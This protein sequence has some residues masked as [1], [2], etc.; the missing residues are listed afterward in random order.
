MAMPESANTRTVMVIGESN[1]GKT[2]YGAQL[3]QRLN[4]Q[5]SVLQM[6]AMP[7]NM[8][9][10]E[11]AMRRIHDGL[12]AEH[13]S[14]TVSAD[15]EWPITAAD[16]QMLD[17]IWP[18][19]GGEQL[20]DILVNRQVPATW[21][22]RARTSDGWLVLAR[23]NHH[24]VD[25]DFMSRPLSQLKQ[26]P[27]VQ[28][29]Y[30]HTSQARLIE[31]LQMLLFMRGADVVAGRGIPRLAVVLSCWDE[32]PADLIARGPPDV[33]RTRMPMLAQFVESVWPANL[34]STLGLSALERALDDK[35]VDE[36]FRDRGPEAFGYTVLGPNART[37]DLCIPL[38]H[39][40]GWR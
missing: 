19:Y 7:S 23:A 31:L 30:R 33:L 36:D 10:F 12:A 18:E 39:I 38:E 24:E 8:T 6:R 16:G 29:P 37:P 32:L 4:S 1:A 5:K 9:A 21:R 14:A 34:R 15:S 11:A 26:A 17:L 28:P 25:G 22:D 13:T 27:T 35:V 2:H 3:L 20:N 40:A